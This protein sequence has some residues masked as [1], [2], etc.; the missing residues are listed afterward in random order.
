MRQ[1]KANAHTVEATDELTSWPLRAPMWSIAVV[2]PA[3]GCRAASRLPPIAW[4][5]PAVR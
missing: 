4:S 1:V 5:L 2:R 3:L